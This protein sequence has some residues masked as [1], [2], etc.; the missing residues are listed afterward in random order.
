MFAGMSQAAIIKAELIGA[1]LYTG[2]MFMKYNAVTR[3]GALSGDQPEFAKEQFEK[4][5]LSN[6][7]VTTI[8]AINSA[9]LKLGKL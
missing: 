3:G 2:P 7:Y 8:H 1:M 5:C 6:R 4:V 9:I